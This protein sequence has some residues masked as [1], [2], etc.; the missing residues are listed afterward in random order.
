MCC[1]ISNSIHAKTWI[2]RFEKNQEDERF[3]YLGEGFMREQKEVE[4]QRAGAPSHVRR[5]VAVVR[6][7]RQRNHALRQRKRTTLSQSIQLPS[8]DAYF[9]A[10]YDRE[11]PPKDPAC[12]LSFKEAYS[13]WLTST[14]PPESLSGVPQDFIGAKW[15]RYSDE[16]LQ[17]QRDTGSGVP[18]TGCE[19]QPQ[20]HVAVLHASPSCATAPPY[21]SPTVQYNTPPSVLRPPPGVATGLSPYNSK[22]QQIQ[23]ATMALEAHTRLFQEQKTAH[24]IYARQAAEEAHNISLT[25]AQLLQQS[26]RLAKLKSDAEN[27]DHDNDRQGGGSFGGGI[28]ADVPQP[29]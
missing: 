12:D 5:A 21:D 15:E 24:A 29:R 28:E 7:R 10:L 11:T 6:A 20:Q 14:Y 2:R 1:A 25:M 8:D 4:L 27:M 13:Q 16:H 26:I 17:G 19:T 23:E 18:P 3:P 22:K 9:G